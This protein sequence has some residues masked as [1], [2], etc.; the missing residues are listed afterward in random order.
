MLCLTCT[1]HVRI[2]IATTYLTALFT[3]IKGCWLGVLFHMHACM[4]TYVYVLLDQSTF[5][6]SPVVTI[7]L[8]VMGLGLVVW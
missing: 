4:Y 2:Y 1:H 6:E 8:L 7:L 5:V 3:F